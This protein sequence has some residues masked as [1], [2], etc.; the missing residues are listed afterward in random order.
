M[1]DIGPIQ[2]DVVIFGGGATGL[3]MLESLIRLDYRVVLLES[4]DLG[5]GQTI[6]SQGIIHGGLKYTLSG[7]F[8]SSA[9]AIREMPGI[10]RQCLA[11]E[12][13]PDL[14]R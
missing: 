9:K 4:G 1:P 11:G 3:W 8:T 10:W 7:L 6:A 14:R 2:F 13:Q 5:S 12:S